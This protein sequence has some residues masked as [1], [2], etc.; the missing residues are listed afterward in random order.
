[1]KETHCCNICGS[2]R[3]RSCRKQKGWQLLE[4]G[5]C[6]FHFANRQ[7]AASAEMPQYDETYFEAFIDRDKQNEFVAFYQATISRLAERAPGRRLLD[8][9]SGASLFSP[10]AKNAGWK[11]TAIDGSSAAV[12]YLKRVFGVEAFVVDLNQD[13]SIRAGCGPTAEFDA[14]NSFHVIE[15]LENPRGY[16]ASCFDA[17][18]KGGVLQLG[19]PYYPWR[20]V[21]FHELLRRIGLTNHPFNF[22]LPDH[23]SFFDEHTIQRLLASVGF[24]VLEFRRTAFQSLHDALEATSDAG[25]LRRF[26]KAAGR[27]ASPITSR[28]GAHQHLEILAI[29]P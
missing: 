29:K 12:G 24:R 15:H 28:I 16:L 10:T 13:K 3:V 26:V 8:A 2:D 11:V 4:C 23:V 1:M 22:N 9:G 27:L 25:R 17:L 18:S 20:R 14:I 7:S 6:S 5:D 21:Q 19:L